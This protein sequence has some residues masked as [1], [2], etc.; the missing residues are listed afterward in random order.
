MRLN[1]Y[2][3]RNIEQRILPHDWLRAFPA[4]TPEKEFSQIW[5]FPRKIDLNINFCLRTF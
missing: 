2:I 4:N 3:Q 5:G 1:D